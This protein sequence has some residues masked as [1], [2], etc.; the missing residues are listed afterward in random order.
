MQRQGLGKAFFQ[1]L[2]AW[3]HEQKASLIE[4]EVAA[5]DRKA[6]GFLKNIGL[7]LFGKGEK[8]GYRSFL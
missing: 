3:G 7:E 6:N 5:S 1:M 4:M 8:N 2:K